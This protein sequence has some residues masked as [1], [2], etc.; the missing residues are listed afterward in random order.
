MICET[1]S[2]D[3]VVIKRHC[4]HFALAPERREPLITAERRQAALAGPPQHPTE[5]I[6]PVS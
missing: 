6:E 3:F 4:L 1:G 5:L 2:H